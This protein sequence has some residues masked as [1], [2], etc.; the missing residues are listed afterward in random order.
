MS[1]AEI[2]FDDYRAAMSPEAHKPLNPWLFWGAIVGTL[3]FF[4]VF[5]YFFVTKG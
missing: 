3:T 4:G 1:L 2:L 5:G